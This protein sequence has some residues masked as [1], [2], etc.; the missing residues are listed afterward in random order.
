MEN[1]KIAATFSHSTNTIAGKARCK[2]RANRRLK[3]ANSFHDDVTRREG[4]NFPKLIILFFQRNSFKKFSSRILYSLA[5]AISSQISLF[6]PL[7][8]LSHPFVYYISNYIFRF[9]SISIHIFFRF[10][11]EIHHFTCNWNWL[12]ENLVRSYF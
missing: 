1:W 10:N 2:I 9:L 6:N 3:R 8:N 4:R 5:P 11:F 7:P 12:M